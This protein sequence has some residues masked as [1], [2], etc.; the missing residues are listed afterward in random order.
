MA[1]WSGHSIR[2]QQLQLG[3][4]S[5]LDFDEAES[6]TVERL[7]GRRGFGG[8][9]PP[10]VQFKNVTGFC[11]KRNDPVS[12]RF[13]QYLSMQTRYVCL[14]VRDAKTGKILVRPPEEHNWLVRVQGGL[15]R[16]DRV[17]KL[18]VGEDELYDLLENRRSESWKLG[19]NDY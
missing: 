5:Y 7:V 15:G 3:I 10:A 14:M 11:I 13:V 12:R 1:Q 6:L 16:D 4:I 8:G 17:E 2:A 18:H 19:F 9:A